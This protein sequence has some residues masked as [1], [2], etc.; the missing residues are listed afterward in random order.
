[1]A[2]VLRT[3]SF[4]QVT[5]NTLRF[6]ACFNYVCSYLTQ[7][8]D[9]RIEAMLT[10]TVKVPFREEVFAQF[11]MLD[12]RLSVHIGLLSFVRIYQ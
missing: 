7:A 5:R 1:M 4:G 9:L 3:G 8:N 2:G 11:D 6:R 10:Q 12:L